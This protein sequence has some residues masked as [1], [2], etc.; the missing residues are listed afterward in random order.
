[1]AMTLPWS[2][3]PAATTPGPHAAMASSFRLQRYRDVVPFLRASM[4]LRRAAAAAPGSVGLGLAASPLRKTFWT[5]STWESDDALRGFTASA[6]HRRVMAR[7]RGASAE[8]RFVFWSI[9]AP[10]APPTWAEARER[11]QAAAPATS[12]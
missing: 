6:E 9:V 8:S 5:L 12:R 7:F 3:G 11:L 2:T 4:R 1:M 10:A